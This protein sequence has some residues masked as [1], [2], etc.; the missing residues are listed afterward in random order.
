MITA[1]VTKAFIG[2]ADGE[3][4]PKKL[5]PGATITGDLARVAIQE[6]NA[7]TADPGK[8]DRLK[9]ADEQGKEE[10]SGAVSLR[11]QASRRNKSRKS[12]RPE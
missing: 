11:G 9:G 7:E 8:P 6:G 4:Y 2:V 3:I 5:H 1:K 10:A 12:E